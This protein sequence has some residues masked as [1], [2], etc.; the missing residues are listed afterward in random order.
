MIFYKSLFRRFVKKQMR[1]FQLAIEDEVERIAEE[2]KIVE[3]KTGDLAGFRVHKFMFQKQQYLIAY[4]VQ[5]HEIIIY[6]V[7][8]HENFYRNLKNYV[9][10]VE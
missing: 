2:P 5:K 8:T 6:M 3:V 4:K 10:E 9:K 7:D 1:P